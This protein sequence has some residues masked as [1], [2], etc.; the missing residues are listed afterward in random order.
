MHRSAAARHRQL[1]LDAATFAR[2]RDVA[3]GAL[4]GGRALTRRDLF[5]TFAAHGISTTGQRAPH[6][7]AYLCQS[8]TLCLGPLQG[9]E[10]AV[11]L[12]AEWVPNP[13]LLDREQALGELV[14]GY[15]ASHGPATER[16]FTR[17][18]GLT[19]RDVALGLAVA[20]DR[21]EPWIVDDTRYWMATG[22]RDTVLASR[23]V[24]LLPGF[25]EYLL[26]YADRSAALADQHREA[27]VPGGNGMFLSTIVSDG[28]VVG[29]WRRRLVGGRLVLTPLP[30]APLAP[31]VE[32][33][34]ATAAHAYARFLG[35]PVEVQS[36][37]SR[38]A[39]ASS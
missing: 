34:F 6:L 11:V 25:D 22:T 30:F 15:F 1:E 5:A 18:T 33:A 12:L 13:R 17:W 35:T 19:A 2:A 10:Q 24:H 37:E 26:G 14:L 28:Q 29:T 36:A 27:I 4:M 21:L 31:S 32:R 16:D 20:G 38:P 8:G 9:A 7:L 39:L 3:V 23:R